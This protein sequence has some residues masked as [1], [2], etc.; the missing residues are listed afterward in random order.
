LDSQRFERFSIETCGL[1]L[2]YSKNRLTNDTLALLQHLATEANLADWIARMF[3]GEKINNTERRAAL[4]IALRNRSNCPISVDGKDVMYDVNAVL[5][6]MRLFS[7]AV[8]E[9]GN[10]AVI[11]VN[12]LNLL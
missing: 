5:A 7:N 10:G 12:P 8:R 11:Q 9:M 4:H 6:K 2:D 1:F 3:Q